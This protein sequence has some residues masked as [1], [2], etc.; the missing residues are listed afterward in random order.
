MS[1]I[2]VGEY[3]RTKEGYIGYYVSILDN[4]VEFDI[5]GKKSKEYEPFFTYYSN[6]KN[7]ALI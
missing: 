4:I 1:E 6:I 3:V 5:S 7:I 2:K